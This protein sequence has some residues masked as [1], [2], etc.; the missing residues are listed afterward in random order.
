MSDGKPKMKED[1]FLTIAR[2]SKGTLFK[3]IC[4]SYHFT[5]SNYPLD[6]EFVPCSK[7]T[8][9]ED[10]A[11][12]K[13]QMAVNKFSRFDLIKVRAIFSN[14]KQDGKLTIIAVDPTQT[15]QSTR[16]TGE[17]LMK[18][19]IYGADVVELGKLWT[20]LRETLEKRKVE[21]EVRL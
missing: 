12:F 20:D 15:I 2:Y 13:R 9:K 3:E 5:L 7:D 1:K 17:K 4:Y 6:R 19:F 18:I 10:L 21:R 8:E 11:R 14:Q 16:N